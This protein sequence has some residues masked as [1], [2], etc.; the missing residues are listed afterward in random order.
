MK[1]SELR[2]GIGKRLC[3]YTVLDRFRGFVRVS[4]GILS[5]V[6]G[7]NVKID[8]EW[9]Y[10]PELLGLRFQDDVAAYIESVKND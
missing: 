1:I 4:H 2:S 6:S 5:E 10:V 8:G 3:W 9:R 7:K